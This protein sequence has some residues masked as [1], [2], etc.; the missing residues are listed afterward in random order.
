MFCG[1]L[2]VCAC[3][4]DRAEAFFDHLAVELWFQPAC[5]QCLPQIRPHPLNGCQGKPLQLAGGGLTNQ[6]PFKVYSLSVSC[7]EISHYSLSLLSVWLEDV[8]LI[9]VQSLFKYLLLC[10][11]NNIAATLAVIY[12]IN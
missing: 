1:C 5:C 12:L 9:H 2:S 4:R 7:L 6:V 11:N 10:D 8:F 3:V